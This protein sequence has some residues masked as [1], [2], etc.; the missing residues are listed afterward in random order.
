MLQQNGASSIV[1]AKS[2]EYSVTRVLLVRTIYCF[3]LTVMYAEFNLHGPLV[4]NCWDKEM[5]RLNVLFVR[6]I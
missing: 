1:V 6:T 3:Q 4:V 2:K 5:W